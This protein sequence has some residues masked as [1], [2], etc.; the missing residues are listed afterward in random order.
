MSL[1]L[2]FVPEAEQCVCYRCR[3]ASPRPEGAFSNKVMSV[4]AAPLLAASNSIA[5]PHCGQPMHNMGPGFVTPPS[6]DDT[7]WQKVAFLVQHDFSFQ[8]G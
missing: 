6:W 1:R 8:I 5:C 3:F 4:G 2:L 7:L